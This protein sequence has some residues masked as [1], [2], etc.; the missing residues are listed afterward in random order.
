MTGG[1]GCLREADRLCVVREANTATLAALGHQEDREV[2]VARVDAVLGSL[3]RCERFGPRVSLAGVA[4]VAV[5]DGRSRAGVIDDLRGELGLRRIIDGAT[6][7][8]ASQS[9]DAESET[10]TLHVARI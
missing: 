7:E 6:G 8:N 4:S 5:G 3:P 10:K 1:V 9:Q 2:P